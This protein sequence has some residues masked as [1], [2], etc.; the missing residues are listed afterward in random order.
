MRETLFEPSHRA[1]YE[2]HIEIIE[3]EI[4]L[5]RIWPTFS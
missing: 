2:N 4:N 1:K 3:P 5:I